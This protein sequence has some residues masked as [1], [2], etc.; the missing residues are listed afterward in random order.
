MLISWVFWNIFLSWISM[1]FRIE[2]LKIFSLCFIT[3]LPEGILAL[4]YLWNR[5][6]VLLC[7]N[8]NYVIIPKIKRWLLCHPHFGEKDDKTIL[9]RSSSQTLFILRFMVDS[10][11]ST[12]NFFFHVFNMMFSLKCFQEHCKWCDVSGR[13]TIELIY[14]KQKCCWNRI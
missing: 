7:S 11:F 9:L 3:P 10:I 6:C 1:T 13:P 4:L 12:E 14:I 5:W 8:E 2:V